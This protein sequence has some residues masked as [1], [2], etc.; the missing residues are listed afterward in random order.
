MNQLFQQINQQSS[1]VQSQHQLPQNNQQINQLQQTFQK[2][3]AMSNPMGYI[4]NI[5]GM[6]DVLSLVNQKGGNAKQLFYSLAQQKGVDP[7]QIL[8]MFK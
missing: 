5:P 3:K 4:Q 2:I 1:D 6:S 8:N 7:E